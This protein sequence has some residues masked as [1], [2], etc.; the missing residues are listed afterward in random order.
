ML[1]LIQKCDLGFG[2]S[3]IPR[4]SPHAEKKNTTAFCSVFFACGEGLGTRLG[5]YMIMLCITSCAC[6]LVQL[7]ASK[8][9]AFE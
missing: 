9:D 6:I 1:S 7:P 2:T 8:L 3:L 5:R 4:P